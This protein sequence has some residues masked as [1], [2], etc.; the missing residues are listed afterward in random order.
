MQ[1]WELIKM[2]RKT[3]TRLVTIE[4]RL[5][6]SDSSEKGN[7]MALAVVADDGDRFIIRQN[8]V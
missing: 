1:K 3:E 4:G 7:P 2:E 5:T 8:G 6:V